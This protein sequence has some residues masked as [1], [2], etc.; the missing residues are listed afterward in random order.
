MDMFGPSE[1]ALH[2]DGHLRAQ[3]WTKAHGGFKKREPRLD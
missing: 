1:E 3:V 2:T